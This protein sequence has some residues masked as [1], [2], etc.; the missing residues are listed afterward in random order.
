MKTIHKYTLTSQDYTL[1]LPKGAEILTVKLQNGVPTLWAI[2][3]TE[4]YLKDS[5]HICIVG[6]GWELNDNMKYIETYMEEY[7]VWHVFEL[8]Q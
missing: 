1:T 5:R 3:D 2:V 6:T 4:E 8:I 7:F